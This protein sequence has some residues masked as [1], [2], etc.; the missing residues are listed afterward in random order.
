MKASRQLSIV[1]GRASADA[2]VKANAIL[3]GA[4]V[5]KL[6]CRALSIVI[7]VILIVTINKSI[8]IIFN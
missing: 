4:S 8:T 6:T 5:E 3:T 7:K 2:I 1:R